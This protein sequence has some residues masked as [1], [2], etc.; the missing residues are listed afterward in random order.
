[1][2][3]QK[4]PTT[5]YEAA[6]QAYADLPQ[7]ADDVEFIGEDFSSSDEVSENNESPTEETAPKEEPSPEE[8]KEVPK[9]E[10]S[11]PEDLRTPEDAKSEEEL[12][13]IRG[14]QSSYTKRMQALSDKERTME[15]EFRKEYESKFQ[16][17]V[18][19]LGQQGQPVQ[20][21]VPKTSLKDYFPDADPKQL[22][23]LEEA[24]NA[25]IENKMSSLKAENEK[26]KEA[27]TARAQQEYLTQQW[28]SVKST[29][30]V[31]DGVL[32][33]LVA[34]SH[35]NPERARGKTIEDIYLISTWERQR[36]V[37][38]KQALSELKKKESESLETDSAPNTVDQTEPKT[39]REAWKLAEQEIRKAKKHK[40][41]V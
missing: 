5:L 29:Y 10:E 26:L 33:D 30:G 41:G 24:F 17:I 9:E 3:D 38:K 12:K 20:T 37:G 31:D 25:M 22:E 23:P 11:L 18:S 8:K 40:K 4:E 7:S 39:L 28:N 16:Q 13:R 19:R 1:M 14:F 6:N 21:N 32:N 36:E 34:W 2:T 27:Y 35:A 15:S